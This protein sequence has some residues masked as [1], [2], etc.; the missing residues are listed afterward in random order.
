MKKLYAVHQKYY[1]N[2]RVEVEIVETYN[3]SEYAV[4]RD[5]YDEYIDVFETRAAA[6]KFID[7]E[8]TE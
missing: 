2:G 5:G 1:D 3:A 6:R 8:L 7:E 4:E